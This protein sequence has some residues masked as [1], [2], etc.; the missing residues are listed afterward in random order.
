MTF[1]K[2]IF[3]RIGY[4]HYY[5]GSQK[6][7]EKP[8]DGGSYNKKGTGSELYNYKRLQNKKVRSNLFGFFQP[9][10]PPKNSGNPVTVNLERIDP[11]KKGNKGN[12]LPKDVLVI[13]ISKREKFGQVIVGWYNHAT[14]FR[15]YQSPEEVMLRNKHKYNLEAEIKNS[16]LLPENYRKFKIPTGK[17]AFGRANVVY[18]SEINGDER[19][20]NSSKFSWIKKAIDYV[21]NY[22]GPNLLIDATGDAEREIEDILETHQLNQSGQGFKIT[23]ELRKKIEEYSVSKAIQYFKNQ[24]FSV[25]YVGNFKSY[26]LDCLKD[27]DTLR[28]EVKGTQTDGNSIILTPNEVKNAKKHKTALYILH[29]INVNIYR[30][31][32][33]LSGGIGKILNPWKIDKQGKLKPLSYMYILD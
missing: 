1:R 21:D 8:K 3:A 6:G 18:L 26:D 22:D 24:D 28:V 7:D 2:A 11:N 19:D 13:F 10:Q 14:V 17:G 4:M 15:E 23:P 16:V 9:F 33:K 30:G 12:N 29:S 20:L 31:K 25:K 5:S 32:Y 27:G